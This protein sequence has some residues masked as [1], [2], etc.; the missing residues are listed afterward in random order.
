M[1]YLTSLFII[2]F[3][4]VIGGCDNQTTNATAS[5]KKPIDKTK[6]SYIAQN[7]DQIKPL[8]I[9]GAKIVSAATK[10]LSRNLSFEIEENG[11]EDAITFCNINAIKITDS[12]GRARGVT[13]RRLAKKNR[14]PENAMNPQESKIYKQYVME[15]LTNQPLKAKIAI[16]NNNRPVYYKP[17]VIR[18]KCLSCHGIIGETLPQ[19]VA[20]KIASLYPSD[21]AIDFKKKHP[22]G[23]WAVTFDDIKLKK[24]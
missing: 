3:T 6:V 24:K 4:I 22:R 21:K 8:Y 13:L 19:N 2:I 15:W 12:I 7:D 20:D 10:E 14:N 5:D 16:N 9:I 18:N 23:M 1:K 11:I 17:I